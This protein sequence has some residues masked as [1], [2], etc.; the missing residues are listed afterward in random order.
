MKRIVCIGGGAGA[1]VV[2]LAAV[3]QYL[4]DPGLAFDVHAVDVADWSGVIEKLEGAWNTTSSSR[5]Q[6][7]HP[8]S[9]AVMQEGQRA[10]ESEESDPSQQPATTEAQPSHA[11]PSAAAESSHH[12][13][14]FQKADILT[15]PRTPTLQSLFTPSRGTSLIITLLFT[16]NELFT[17]SLSQTT[18]LLLSLTDLTPPG[19]VLI[20]IDSPGSYSEV[21]VGANE[22]PKKRYPMRFLLDHTLMSVASEGGKWEKFVGE[23]ARWFRIDEG[24]K[25]IDGGMGYPVELENMRYQIHGYR[26]L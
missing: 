10:E 3:H 20:V 2:A 19:T 1:E 24:L 9:E 12:H 21:S 4:D 11:T 7:P 26:H 5:V 13:A 25:G 22:G 8:Q 17:T 18:H 16:L 23:E 6:N 14:T 15:L